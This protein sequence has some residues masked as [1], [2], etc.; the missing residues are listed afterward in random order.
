MKYTMMQVELE[1][2]RKQVFFSKVFAQIEHGEIHDVR[3][4][5]KKTNP[6]SFFPRG[7]SV[8]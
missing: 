1:S 6:G 2:K 5:L 7:L 4:A 8:G 3:T